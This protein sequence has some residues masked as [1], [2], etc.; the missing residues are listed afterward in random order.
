MILYGMSY[1]GK[2]LDVAEHNRN[3]VQYSYQGDLTLFTP[4]QQTKYSEL[5]I[6]VVFTILVNLISTLNIHPILNVLV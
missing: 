6:K 3:I 5:I 2:P 4:H 1:R